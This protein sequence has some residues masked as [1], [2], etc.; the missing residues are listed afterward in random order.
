VKY[1][2]FEITAKVWL[3]HQMDGW[4]F[5]TIP[6]DVTKEIDAGFADRKRGWGSLPVIA[7]IGATSWRTSIFSVKKEG[8]YILPLKAQVRKKENI[9][10]GDTLKIL[11]EIAV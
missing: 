2:Q 6:K 3:Y 9:T 8:T 10:A 5:V 4:H 7:Y 1:N 11:I